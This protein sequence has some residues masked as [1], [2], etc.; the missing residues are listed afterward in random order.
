MHVKMRPNTIKQPRPMRLY[1][2]IKIMC[3]SKRTINAL[4][5]NK[6]CIM[7]CKKPLRKKKAAKRHDE[8]DATTYNR[9]RKQ[10]QSI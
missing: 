10:T 2:F 6:Y 3:C 9:A 4:K 5:T 8:G 7:K 1:Y